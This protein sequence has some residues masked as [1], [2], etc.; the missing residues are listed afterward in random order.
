MKHARGQLSPKKLS[1]AL[2][3]QKCQKPDVGKENAE[4]CKLTCLFI[5]SL[6][7]RWSSSPLTAVISDQRHNTSVI[8]TGTHDASVISTATNPLIDPFLDCTSSFHLLVMP[9]PPTVPSQSHYFS[10]RLPKVQI[11]DLEAQDWQDEHRLTH[12]PRARPGIPCKI[13]SILELLTHNALD[14]P[15]FFSVAL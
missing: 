5:F 4:A 8:N 3:P 7:N 2:S 13:G 12:V 14:W 6:L 15:V 10:Y 9:E 11:E 1:A